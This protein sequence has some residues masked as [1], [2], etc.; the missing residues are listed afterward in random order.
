MLSHATSGD[1]HA[2]AEPSVDEN[3]TDAWMLMRRGAELA[4]EATSNASSPSSGACVS[5]TQALLELCVL[6][7]SR[8]RWE[9]TQPHL[10]DARPTPGITF[11]HA[12]FRVQLQQ[13]RLEAV[14]RDSEAG[15][16]AL[17]PLQRQWGTVPPSSLSRSITLC[18]CTRLLLAMDDVLAA[19]MHAYD[20]ITPS[21]ARTLQYAADLHAL[22]AV[23]VALLRDVMHTVWLRDTAP[24]D[25]SLP[26]VDALLP[27]AAPADCVAIMQIQLQLASAAR[28]SVIAAAAICR[29]KAA[30]CVLP[31]P[32]ICTFVHAIAQHAHV[33][34]DGDAWHDVV[35][36][37][38]PVIVAEPHAPA[39][40]PT[41]LYSIYTLSCANIT[42]ETLVNAMRMSLSGSLVLDD[43]AASHLMAEWTAAFQMPA[44]GT[45]LPHAVLGIAGISSILCKRHELGDWEW[46]LLTP[47]DAT[48]RSELLR[49]VDALSRSGT[50]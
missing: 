42:H 22:A 36:Q 39:S 46:P 27:A 7:V 19:L 32:V 12:H 24:A 40:S 28:D 48:N 37:C 14:E 44:A 18:A 34:V 45:L 2:A 4:G 20:S 41:T 5:F 8:Q 49:A 33:H 6:D 11:M 47:T 1:A 35:Q 25:A 16:A 17:E 15:A 43:G 10:K 30:M 29:M 38:M 9:H 13:V 26:S 31:A 50:H 23:A 21:R 3:A